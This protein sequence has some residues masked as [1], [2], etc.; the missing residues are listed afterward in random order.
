MPG[1]VPGVAVG[2]A[3]AI[4]AEEMHD[5]KRRAA[6]DALKDLSSCSPIFRISYGPAP[7]SHMVVHELD[8]MALA[9]ALMLLIEHG[10]CPAINLAR[11]KQAL[12]GYMTVWRNNIVEKPAA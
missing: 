11:A 7:Q 6:E 8:P 3:P 4:T 10:Q 12:N 1:Q 5:K 2:P 9:A